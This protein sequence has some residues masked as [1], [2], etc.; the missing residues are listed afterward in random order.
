MSL[1]LQEPGKA[2]RFREFLYATFLRM[3]ALVLLFHAITFWLYLTGAM[4]PDMRFDTMPEHWQIAATVLAV[5]MPV[6]ALGLWGRFPWGAA[7]WFIVM[8]IELFMFYWRTDLFGQN[9]AIVAFHVLTFAIFLVFKL[10][11]V[12]LANRS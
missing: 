1:E 8:G 6:A 9:M 2:E 11:G 4:S 12:F 5:V 10:L 3:V 7:L